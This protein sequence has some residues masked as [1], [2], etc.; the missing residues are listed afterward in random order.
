MSRQRCRL[1]FLIDRRRRFIVA[2]SWRVKRRRSPRSVLCPTQRERQFV[3]L[4]LLSKIK[5]EATVSSIA[6]SRFYGDGTLGWAALTNAWTLGTGTLIF[7]T[8]SFEADRVPSI[9]PSGIDL[10]ILLVD[11][12][13][14]NSRVISASPSEI[15]I[16]LD[17]Y[18]RRMTP[19]SPPLPPGTRGFPGSGWI[20]GSRV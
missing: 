18:R 1:R 8:A 14:A 20:L 5:F 15:V 11:G 6:T 4:P 10:P 9:P 12:A 7:L 19:V 13:V 17:G 3:T 16:E 2:S